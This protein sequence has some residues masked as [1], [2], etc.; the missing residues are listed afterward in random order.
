MQQLKKLQRNP[1]QFLLRTL[2]CYFMYSQICEALPR[3]PVSCC[4]GKGNIQSR[5]S[6]EKCTFIYEY[7]RSDKIMNIDSGYPLLAS[8]R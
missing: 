3:K 8:R 4:F 5:R 6:A 2:K 7:Y 1:P